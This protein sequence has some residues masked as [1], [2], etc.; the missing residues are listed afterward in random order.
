MPDR[1][2]EA[3]LAAI[4]ASTLGHYEQHAADYWAGTREHD[5]SQ[6]IDALLRHI[7]GAP[8]FTVLDFGCGPGRDLR[9]FAALGHVAI[10]LE[11]AANAAALARSNSGCEVWQQ[12]F[13]RL[14][15]PAARFDGVFAN[16]SLFHVPGQTLPGVLRALHATL[17][18]GGA[19]FSSNPRGE[20]QEGWNDARYGAYHDLETWRRY[21]DDAGFVELEHYYRP[22]GLPREQQPW[23]ASVWRKT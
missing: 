18:A 1:L 16:A 5:V 2:S 3:D 19:L 12:D 22:P 15:L 23:L 13:L 4:S 20:N 10:G 17:K 14:E 11:G 9:T 6:N 7:G 8:P 21:L